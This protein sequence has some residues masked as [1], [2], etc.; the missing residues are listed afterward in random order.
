MVA[1]TPARM[2]E[3]AAIVSLHGPFQEKKK[4]AR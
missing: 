4:F 2:Y 1:A 3:R